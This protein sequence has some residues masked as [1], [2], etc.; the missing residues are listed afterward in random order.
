MGTGS[1]PVL[2]PFEAGGR[3]RIN[4][5]SCQGVCVGTWGRKAVEHSRLRMPWR[6]SRLRATNCSEMNVAAP[7]RRDDER[8]GLTSA[9]FFL[10]HAA[11]LGVFFVPFSWDCVAI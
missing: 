1:L 11:A 3:E 6:T 8:I 9:P 10:V 4:A 2:E 5:G 7:S